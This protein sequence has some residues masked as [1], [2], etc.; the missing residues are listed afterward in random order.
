MAQNSE[1]TDFVNA[2]LGAGHDRD[3]IAR[4]LA[5]AGWSERERREA[6]E[7]WQMV[8]GLPPVPRPRAYVS[9]REAVIY[10]LLFIALCVVAWHLCSLGFR[11]IDAVLPDPA[12]LYPQGSGGMRWSMAALIVFT[13]VFALLNRHVAIQAAQ[14]PGRRRSLVRRWFASVTLLIC[15][16]TLLGDL[17]LTLYSFLDGELT[18]RLLAKSLLLAVVAGLVLAYYRDELD[19]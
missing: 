2:A 8:A 4:A 13:P 10:G 7:G 3:D 16:L 12:A 11:V 14:D 5:D 9:A 1:L 17:V 18:P 6:L 15:A 19:G